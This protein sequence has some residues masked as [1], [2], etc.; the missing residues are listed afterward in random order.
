MFRRID[1]N[2]QGIVPPV[3]YIE[4]NGRTGKE[5]MGIVD[6]AGAVAQRV[7]IDAVPDFNFRTAVAFEPAMWSCR[8]SRWE[9]SFPRSLCART[10]FT[11]PAGLMMAYRPVRHTGSARSR[12][13]RRDI[14]HAHADFDSLGLR[15]MKRD[16]VFDGSND[17]GASG[18][19]RSLFLNDSAS[20]HGFTGIGID[21]RSFFL[22]PGRAPFIHGAEGNGIFGG[23]SILD[24]NVRSAS[25]CHAHGVDVRGRCGGLCFLLEIAGT[26]RCKCGESNL[27]LIVIV[28]GQGFLG[29]GVVRRKWRCLDGIR[30]AP[31]Y[32][33]QQKRRTAIPIKH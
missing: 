12:T 4:E 18:A 29:S 1:T 24:E 9:G 3:R 6:V 19:G 20:R 11:V 13:R 7:G 25:K 30:G 33:N 32:G 31:G 14:A 23:H 22:H 16:D 28:D 21:D 27:R 10:R 5:R 26:L 17:A 8:V 15:S 2:R